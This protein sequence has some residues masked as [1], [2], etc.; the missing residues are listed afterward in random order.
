MKKL[1]YHL[2]AALCSA[3]LCCSC[4]RPLDDMAISPKINNGPKAI[5]NAP[6]IEQVAYTHQ[7]LDVVGKSLLYV[8]NDK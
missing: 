6:Y 3:L 2:G 1:S 7:H 5:A 8:L 4:E